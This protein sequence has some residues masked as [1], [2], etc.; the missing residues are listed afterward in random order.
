MGNQLNNET[1]V[2]SQHD[3]INFV[4]F[5]ALAFLVDT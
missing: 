2:T 3:I 4:P 1:H 5:D